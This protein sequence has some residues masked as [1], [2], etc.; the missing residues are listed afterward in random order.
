MTEIDSLLPTPSNDTLVPHSDSNYEDRGRIEDTVISEGHQQTGLAADGNFHSSESNVTFN[1]TQE[2]EASNT[3]PDSKRPAP[4]AKAPM[5]AHSAPS[6][7]IVKKVSVYN[8]L[9]VNTL[10]NNYLDYQFRNVRCWFRQTNFCQASF[11][12]FW[13]QSHRH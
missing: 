10:N 7:P 13:F 6:T 5:P 3:N 11:W 8:V 1:T 2:N 4:T 9:L 12:F